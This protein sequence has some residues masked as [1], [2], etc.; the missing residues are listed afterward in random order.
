MEGRR[1]SFLDTLSDIRSW[2]VYQF[3]KFRSHPVDLRK[4]LLWTLTPVIAVLVY[5][6]FFQRRFKPRATGGKAAT[7][8]PA[9][10]PGHDS[11]FYQLETALAACGLVR[12][13]QEALSDWLERT[14]LDPALAGLRTPLQELLRLHY[15]YRFDPPG[16]TGAEKLAFIQA[17]ETILRTLAQRIAPR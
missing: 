15:R 10:W 14:L 4:Y 7:T 16:L 13:P 5:Y 6:I 11:A 3:E 8:A 2:L 9:P 1:A 17:V 12:Q